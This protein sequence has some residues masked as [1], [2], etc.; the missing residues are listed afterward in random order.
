MFV[1]IKQ[2]SYVQMAHHYSTITVR[3]TN[4]FCLLHCPSMAGGLVS[5][6]QWILTFGR[7]TS[8]KHTPTHTTGLRPFFRNHP[9]ESVPEENLW[10]L[11]CKGRLT[12]A[13]TATI[14]LG[15]TP[16]GLISAHL[17][18]TAIFTA[19][20]PFLPPHQQCQSTEGNYCIRS[21]EKMLEFSM[22]LPAPS[23]YRTVSIQVNDWI[24][25]MVAQDHQTWCYL[26]GHIIGL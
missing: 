11:W 21:R 8:F 10:T 25:T 26:I 5:G 23:L 20:M 1:H 16:S 18:Q 22:V 9:V 14:R 15:A 4:Y 2:N 6:E 17:H 19:Q 7:I 3:K 24:T 12:E 13:D